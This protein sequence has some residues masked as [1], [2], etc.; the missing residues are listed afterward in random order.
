MIDNIYADNAKQVY[1]DVFDLTTNTVVA[2]T[3]IT[4]NQWDLANEYETFYVPFTA[5]SSTAS[6]QLQF[7]CLWW[8]QAN[9]TVAACGVAKLQ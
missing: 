4:R 8:G 3:S 9:V 7:R 2:A 6:H 5:T 1:L